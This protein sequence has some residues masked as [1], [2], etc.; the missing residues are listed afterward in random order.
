MGYNVASDWVD[1]IG[2]GTDGGDS[3]PLFESYLQSGR[4]L[5]SYDGGLELDG[6]WDQIHFD[7]PFNPDQYEIISVNVD[8]TNNS[9][10]LNW[11]ELETFE[12]QSTTFNI[13]SFTSFVGTAGDDIFIGNYE[14]NY[15]MLLY[16]GDDVVHGGGN[17]TISFETSDASVIVN[18][19][20]ANS[21]AQ[22][23]LLSYGVDETTYT[24]NYTTKFDGIRGVHGTW[25]DD[26][27]TVSANSSNSY[28]LARSGNDTIISNGNTYISPGSGNDN[29]TGSEYL[30]DEVSYKDLYH[31]GNGDVP[32]TGIIVDTF[33]ANDYFVIDSWGDIDKLTNIARIEGT[34]YDD[35]FSASSGRDFFEAGDGTDKAIFSGSIN[36]HTINYI[37]N[38]FFV[39]ENSSSLGFDI[40]DNFEILQFYDLTLSGTD[41]VDPTYVSPITFGGITAITNSPLNDVNII[42]ENSWYSDPY[43]G[44]DNQAIVFSL[45]PIIGDSNYLLTGVTAPYINPI[46]DAGSSDLYK[47]N[48]NLYDKYSIEVNISPDDLALITDLNSSSQIGN[49]LGGGSSATV[50]SISKTIYGVDSGDQFDLGTRTFATPVDIVLAINFGPEVTFSG[51]DTLIGGSGNNTLFGFAGNDTIDGGAG[52]DWLIGGTGHNTLIGGD[53]VDLAF[54]G[55]PTYAAVYTENGEGITVNLQT[56]TRT[57]GGG[58]DKL[59]SIEEVIGSQFD[60]RFIGNDG[61]NY[62]EGI[63]GNDDFNGAEGS[64]TVGYWVNTGV[65]VDLENNTAFNAGTTSLGSDSADSIQSIRAQY[66]NPSPPLLPPE[67][68]DEVGLDTFTSIENVVGSGFNDLLIGNQYNNRFEGRGGNDYIIGGEGQDTVSYRLLG[69]FGDVLADSSYM[70]YMTYMTDMTDMSGQFG[71]YVNLDTNYAEGANGFDKLDSMERVAGSQFNDIIHGSSGNNIFYA[72]GGND[73]INGNGGSDQLNFSEISTLPYG[74]MTTGITMTLADG[75]MGTVSFSGNTISYSSIED[76][77]GS[78]LDDTLTGNSSDNYLEGWLGNDVLDGGAGADTLFGGAGDDIYYVDSISDV[79]VELGSD[80]TKDQLIFSMG[81]MNDV[82]VVAANATNYV[83]TASANVEDM[84]AAGTYTGA[85]SDVAIDMT[86]NELAQ[87]LIGNNA[88]NI[89]TGEAGDD[90][91]VGWGGDDTLFGGD[92]NDMFVGGVGNDLMQGGAGSDA[93]LFNYKFTEGW[94]LL[95]RSFAPVATGGND[96]VDGGSVSGSDSIYMSGSL[97]DY[98]ITFTSQTAQYKIETNTGKGANGAAESMVFRNIET[99]NFGSFDD[100]SGSFVSNSTYNLVMG[101]SGN[102]RLNGPLNGSTVDDYI[103]GGAGNDTMVGG[104][105]NDVY[106]VDALGDVVT[107]IK[108][109]GTDT[110][111]TTLINFSIA[112]LVNVENLTFT[113]IG[114]ATLTGNAGNNVITG[115]AGTDTLIGGLGNDTYV[116]NSMAD[117]INEGTGTVAGA[118]GTDTVVSSVSY[119]LAKTGLLENLTLNYGNATT[120]F[121]GMGNDLA[122]V[123]T[124]G[125]AGD[126]LYGGVGNDTIFGHGGKDTLRG[127]AGNDILEGGEGNDYLLGGVGIDILRGGDGDDTLS[128]G[129]GGAVDPQKPLLNAD[130]LDGGKG[131]DTYLINEKRTVVVESDTSYALSLSDLVNGKASHD[132]ILSSVDFDISTVNA[133]EDL[134]LTGM[135]VKATG[136]DQINILI[137]NLADNILLGNDGDDALLGDASFIGG[138]E[139]FGDYG[140]SFKEAD[141]FHLIG[142]DDSLDGGDGNDALMGMGGSD[143]LAGGQG[144]DILIGGGGSDTY[145]VDHTADKVYESLLSG[146]EM[147]LAILGDKN[148]KVFNVADFASTYYIDQ[149]KDTTAW[150]ITEEQYQ[151]LSLSSGFNLQVFAQETSYAELPNDMPYLVYDTVNHVE[152]YYYLSGYVPSGFTI[153][154]A[155]LDAGGNDWIYQSV[156]LTNSNGD[157]LTLSEFSPFVENIKLTGLAISAVGSA[158][159]N[160][161]FGSETDNQIFGLEG[162]DWISAGA[163]NDF[164]DGGLGDDFIDGGAGFDAV[165]YS[166]LKDGFFDEPITSGINANLTTNVVTTGSMGTDKLSGIEAIVGTAYADVFVGDGKDNVFFGNAGNDT[167]D[168]SA[169]IDTYVMG[170]TGSNWSIQFLDQIK[171]IKDITVGSDG[172]LYV[173]GKYADLPFGAYSLGGSDAVLA[174]FD[175][176][177]AMQWIRTFGSTGDDVANALTI[178]SDGLIYVGGETTGSFDGQSNE[179]NSLGDIDGFVTVFD[180]E[181]AKQWT[182]FVGTSGSDAVTGLEFGA[183]NTLYIAGSTT[184]N[185]NNVSSTGTNFGAFITKAQ[186]GNGTVTPIWTEI[187]GNTVDT[188]GY[189]FSISADGSSLYLAGATN[190]ALNGDGYNGNTD[191]FV[192][193]YSSDGSPRWIRNINSHDGNQTSGGQEVAWTVA[194]D[195]SDGSVYVGGYFTGEFLSG[196][197]D[198]ANNASITN[199]ELSF[200]PDGTGPYSKDFFVIKYSSKG[201]VLWSKSLGDSGHETAYAMSVAMDGSLFVTGSTSENPSDPN[202]YSMTDVMLT[203]L[204][205]TGSVLYEGSFGSANKVDVGRA[206]ATGKFGEIYLGG[207]SSDG[208]SFIYK[209]FPSGVTIDFTQEINL[210]GAITYDDAGQILAIDRSKAT[211]VNFSEATSE[212]KAI[213]LD[214]SAY[215]LG[216]DK[217]WNMEGMGLTFGN[218]SFIGSEFAETIW[219]M[220]GNDVLNGGE[221][222]DVLFGDFAYDS[223]YSNKNMGA[224]T[225][226]GQDTFVGGEGND[227]MDGGSDTDVVD[228]SAPTYRGGITVDFR[229]SSAGVFKATVKANATAAPGSTG[230]DVLINIEKVI[231]TWGDDLFTITDSRQIVIG[232]SGVDKV[233]TTMQR[234]E[235]SSVPEYGIENLETLFANGAYL[236]GDN[237]NNTIKGAGGADTLLGLGGND[238]LFGGDGSDTVSFGFA[239]QSVLV[240]LTVGTASGE[241]FDTLVG[242]ENVIGSNFNDRI[243]GNAEANTLNGGLGADFMA[244][245]AGNDVYYVNSVLDQVMEIRGEG[246]DTV[247]LTAA[248]NYILASNV[249][250]LDASELWEIDYTSSGG[251]VSDNVFDS[252]ARE[253]WTLMAGNSRSNTIIGGLGV[254][255]LMG[256]GVGSSGGTDLLQGG[257]GGDMYL[258]DGAHVTIIENFNEGL[259]L[260]LVQGDSYT[261]GDNIEYAMAWGEDSYVSDANLRGNSLDNFLVGSYGANTIEGGE[262]NDL[263]AGYGGDDL[264]IGGTGSD[265]FVWSQQGYEGVIADFSSAAKD[266]IALAFTPSDQG[267]NGLKAMKYDLS[268]LTNVATKGGTEFTL[269]STSDASWAQ[270]IY[271]PTSG[272]LQ[273]DMPTWNVN[274]WV[275]R[276]GLADAQML[277]NSA[278]SGSIPSLTAI[279]TDTDLSTMGDFI[280]MSDARDYTHHPMT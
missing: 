76:I 68:W 192:T 26:T 195:K 82:V 5:I 61:D 227:T 233:T 103:N 156:D 241:G 222:D 110:I 134:R 93:F 207:D 107:E 21:T 19:D 167:A 57:G 129:A 185:L 112:A 209:L 15:F 242:I 50:S 152:P 146:Y 176:S 132:I 11:N 166:G 9:A 2:V 262:G 275:A 48:Q 130:T 237:F 221:G 232:G 7:Y 219:G 236:G 271:D 243:S 55:D 139:F 254:D 79:V 231:G 205:S 258:Y 62:F 38:I 180:D 215:G 198:N 250:V 182:K 155:R 95:G 127:G 135:A 171:E 220:G 248:V 186:I 268:L 31:D 32:Q 90:A 183:D 42:P 108:D 59:V 218:D 228:Y 230:N 24:T 17:S 102:D 264:L 121:M 123:M 91:L 29:I 256:G 36:D 199:S 279:D 16:G 252:T 253:Q 84:M 211:L 226:S 65:V 30:T 204:S 189:A 145:F 273:I 161:L 193:N 46:Y 147:E 245:G 194:T 168:G 64:D 3:L 51:D 63:A 278:V 109:A 154:A 141:N 37:G 133:V 261:L 80:N 157:L 120:S 10:V 23:T 270:V 74:A 191:A 160:M 119:I 12:T 118:G 260:V 33:G 116:V 115:G 35:I 88:K 105:G 25:G 140:N 138:I 34:D 239:T 165:W 111:Q 217:F 196:N 92:G 86:G 234:Y 216:V 277:V 201:E 41:L 240:D 8:L 106:V 259:D 267:A 172:S 18:L 113:G 14:I 249:E 247:H 77:A 128:G 178:G 244:G 28:I 4:S 124:G 206:M 81:N 266:K 229:E 208:S 78:A 158:D 22:L 69:L 52:N 47:S 27:I 96:T 44:G 224:W 114:N 179:S 100:T 200:L 136:N 212:E 126:R 75:G 89:L 87:G 148:G 98:T 276:D 94:D 153:S 144:A 163:G 66:Q 269:N 151:Q 188:E 143:I 223:Q 246:T 117:K 71:M 265:A 56:G 255:Y 101:T 104:T 238:T 257:M 272:L 202:T 39:K 125:N 210:N 53:G 13:V 170:S 203:K 54:Y 190:G 214:L 99:F 150:R 197:L 263:I 45:Q 43:S 122:N 164:I 175:S 174:K 187:L 67:T 173:V 131:N 149:A 1:S 6:E 85:A 274:Q 83:L 60:D 251:I 280:I 184:G 181:G 177:G 162:N 235:L 213:I 73:S 169:G 97:C 20:G 159:S 58:T 70:T 49:L 225:D 40:L 142:G 72:S 137:G